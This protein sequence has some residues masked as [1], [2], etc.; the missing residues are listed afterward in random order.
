[1][2]AHGFEGMMAKRLSSSYRAGRSRDWLK[3]KDRSY[4]RKAALGIG[5]KW[6]RRSYSQTKV[7]KLSALLIPIL[8]TRRSALCC[9]IQLYSNLMVMAS[10]CRF[11]T[12]RKR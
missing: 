1:V 12:S 8:N 10:A 9:V 2:R 3:I 11:A 7:L 5:V 6:K 4:P